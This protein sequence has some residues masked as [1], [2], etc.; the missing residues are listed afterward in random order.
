MDDKSGL[1]AILCV[2]KSVKLCSM[3]T[4]HLFRAAV[5][6]LIGKGFVPTRPVVL[7][8]GFDEEASG[9]LVRP[10]DNSIW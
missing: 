10:G 1:I 9:D 8:F 6:M 2:Y 7:S 4:Q 5:E 3:L